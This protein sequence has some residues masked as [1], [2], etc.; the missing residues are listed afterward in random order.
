MLY[1]KIQ[2]LSN[3][4]NALKSFL[5]EHVRIKKNENIFNFNFRVILMLNDDI[6]KTI[7]NNI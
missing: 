1:S 3:D 5:N 7:I 6:I 4:K 2:I